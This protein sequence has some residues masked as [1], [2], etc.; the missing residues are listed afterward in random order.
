MSDIYRIEFRAMGCK[1]EVQLET[2]ADGISL[3]NQ[4]PAKLESYE[5]ILSRFREHS[6]L[7]YLNRHAGQWVEVSDVLFDVIQQAKHGA[8]RT[9]GLY[10]PLVLQ[11]MI[12]N[13]YYTSFEAIGQPI[14]KLPPKVAKWEHI[15]LRL[16]TKHVLLPIGS[17][18]DLGGIAKGWASA[19]IADELH[20]YGA[21]LVN[22][23]GDITMRGAPSGQSGWEIEIDDPLSGQPLTTLFL[24]DTTII[25]S[26][27]DYRRWV[28]ADGQQRHHIID[29]RTGQSAITDVLAATLIHPHAP[30]AEAFAK[31]VLLMRSSTGLKWLHRHWQAH[32]LVVRQD[33]CV[34]ATPNFNNLL[35]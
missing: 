18:I 15:G 10:N 16:K 27:M 4:M 32:G 2:E 31:A 5:A 1:V 23:G 9:D 14:T 34:M 19:K 30:S 21:C 11:Q 13:G 6:E 29:P 17:A 35:N 12:A 20:Q 8:R 33:G 24:K 7:S 22:I 26:G 25:T 28:G 3:L